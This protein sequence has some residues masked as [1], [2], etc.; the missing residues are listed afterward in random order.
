MSGLRARNAAPAITDRA[1]FPVHRNRT[2]VIAVAE[3]RRVIVVELLQ[4]EVAD[5]ATVVDAIVDVVNRAYTTAETELW[6]RPLPRTDAHE[7]RTAIAN[8][9]VA[10]ARLDDAIVGSLFVRLLDRETGWFGAL[11]VDPGFGGRGIGGRLV[12]FAEQ[13][14]RAA[15]AHTMQLEL[16]V[17]E[18]SIA[19]TD[20]LASWYSALGYREVASRDLAELDPTCIDDALVEIRVSVMRKPLAQAAR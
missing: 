19:H 10:V 6:R 13:R 5:D 9:E 3:Y 16:L 2:V 14:A 8:R 1:A 4:A 17:P 20:R 7:T 12:D 18:R 11:G 15:G